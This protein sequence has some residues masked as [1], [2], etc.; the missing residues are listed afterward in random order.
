VILNSPF[1]ITTVNKPTTSLT[2]GNI[3]VKCKR[4][5]VFSPILEALGENNK[6]LIDAMECTSVT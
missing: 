5:N 2:F 3:S 1:T 6:V 4:S